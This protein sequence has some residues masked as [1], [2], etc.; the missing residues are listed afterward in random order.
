[1]D[2]ARGIS[3]HDRLGPGGESLDLLADPGPQSQVKVDKLALEKMARLRIASDFDGRVWHC[4]PA[5]RIYSV[6][7]V[8]HQELQT[9]LEVVASVPCHR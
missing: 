7:G 4:P 2:D 3:L 6:E 5:N 1:M 8:H 9:L